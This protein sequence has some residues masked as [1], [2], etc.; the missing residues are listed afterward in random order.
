[1]SACERCFYFDKDVDEEP[2]SVCES[3]GKGGVDKFKPALQ[4]E[5]KPKKATAIFIEDDI[6]Q[7]EIK[8]V[9]DDLVRAV[10]D[11]T[12]AFSP[13][14]ICRYYLGDSE[15]CQQCCYNYPSEFSLRGAK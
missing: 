3:L 11:F 10:K 4:E 14:K 15:H 8:S 2:C 6:E 12:L 7:E 9:S 1:M 5:P 13:C